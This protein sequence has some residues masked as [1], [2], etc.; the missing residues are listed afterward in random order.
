MDEVDKVLTAAAAILEKPGAWTQGSNARDADGV[1]V[2]VDSPYAVCF[3]VRGALFIGAVENR[4][5]AF[6]A[7]VRFS[8]HVMDA[9]AHWNDAEERTQTEVVAALRAA[10]KTVTA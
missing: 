4:A 5:Y 1:P 10:R 6:D 9:T 7:E 3:C 8:A 2:H